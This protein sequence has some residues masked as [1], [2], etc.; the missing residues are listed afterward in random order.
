MAGNRQ[1]QLIGGENYPFFFTSRVIAPNPEGF[2][3]FFI[4]AVLVENETIRHELYR[5]RR[6]IMCLNAKRGPWQVRFLRT[7]MH[8]YFLPS[9]RTIEESREQYLATRYRELKVNV[10][11]TPPQYISQLAQVMDDLEF[12]LKNFSL[13]FTDQ[14]GHVLDDQIETKM[15]ELQRHF[16]LLESLLLNRY[17]EMELFWPVVIKEHGPVRAASF[18]TCQCCLCLCCPVVNIDTETVA[19][20]VGSHDD[21][22]LLHQGRS[23][24]H[25]HCRHFKQFRSTHEK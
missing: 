9:I 25:F 14:D 16:D 20:S 1:V 7:W 19:R 17:D 24:G 3:P 4:S 15:V 5:C 11:S 8:E 13:L 10:P 22:K 6:T 12:C 23:N 2:Y 21:R 18:E